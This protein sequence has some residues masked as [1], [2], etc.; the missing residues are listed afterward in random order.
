M[1]AAMAK[2]LEPANTDDLVVRARTEAEA[3][4]QLYDLY[5][6]RILRFSLCRVFNRQ[7]AEDITSLVFLAVARRI[8]DFKGR[9]Q[10]EFRSWLYRIAANHTNSYIRKTSRHKRLLDEAARSMRIKVA[11]E[12]DE[13]PE[14]DWPM[15]HAAISKLKPKQQ[16]IVTLRFFE[17]MDFEEIGEIVNAQPG[18]VRVALSRGLKKLKSHLQTVEDG[19]A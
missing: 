3:L 5:Y 15:L 6:D 13:T 19:G 2:T 7:T 10:V 4:G 9:T 16:T 14:P 18:A 17:N 8:P 11:G 12:T 1:V